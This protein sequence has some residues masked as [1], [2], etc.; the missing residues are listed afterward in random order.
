[1]GSRERYWSHLL[2]KVRAYLLAYLQVGVAKC[3]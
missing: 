1:M 3:N 2:R